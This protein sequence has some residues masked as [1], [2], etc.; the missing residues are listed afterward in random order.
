MAAR[1]PK[2]GISYGEL[3]DYHACVD[4]VRKT[5]LA[6][7]KETRDYISIE[8]ETVSDGDIFSGNVRALIA[9][10]QKDLRQIDAMAKKYGSE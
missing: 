6:I 7:A 1:R 2:A 10:M 5:A 8:G 3:A 4:D 9:R